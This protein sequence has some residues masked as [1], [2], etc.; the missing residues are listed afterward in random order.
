MTNQEI[1]DEQLSNAEESMETAKS[2]LATLKATYLVDRKPYEESIAR[3]RI[4]LR[5]LRAANYSHGRA[6]PCDTC[7]RMYDDEGK[8]RTR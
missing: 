7:S 1:L 5:A 2:N 8:R 3:T 4:V 6:C